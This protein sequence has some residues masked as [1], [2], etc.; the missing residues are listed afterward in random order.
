MTAAVAESFFWQAVMEREL[1]KT[2][3][4][5]RKKKEQFFSNWC[6]GDVRVTEELWE[7]R[8]QVDIE[9]ACKQR[10]LQALCFHRF[11]PFSSRCSLQWS[12]ISPI[13]F[14]NTQVSNYLCQYFVHIDKSEQRSRDAVPEERFTHLYSHDPVSSFCPHFRRVV[15][16]AWVEACPLRGSV[17][18]D[19]QKEPELLYSR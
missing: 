9:P 5:G 19:W 1:Y 10:A 18:W 17:E 3:N 11:S 2:D 15:C 14:L 8:K 6:C 13:A 4:L 7:K 16:Q 12:L